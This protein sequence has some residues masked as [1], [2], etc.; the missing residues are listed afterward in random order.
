MKSA[1]MCSLTF[2]A[3]L[4]FLKVTLSELCSSVRA[5]RAKRFVAEGGSLHLSC[6]V[7]HCGLPGWTGGWYFQEL[8]RIGF[9]LLT[10]SER[11]KMSNY[12]STANSTHLLLHIHNINQSDA[13][14]YMCETSWPNNIIS[15]GHLTYVNVTAAAV[16]AGAGAANSSDRSLSH[17]VLLCFGALMCFPVVLGF[18]WC[19]TR[20]H[21][22]P[23]PPVPPHPRM[24]YAYR[25]KP[26]QEVVYAEV[27]LNDSRRQ[28]DH[29]KQASEPTFY[30]SVHFS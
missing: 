16:G 18:V 25:V 24:S 29:P 26:K 5:S 7:Q 6:E 17:R 12:S 21:H 8:D 28:N 14:A 20:D 27:A 19:L 23:P 1:H 4:C 2:L 30:S 10:P 3:L 22:P 15:K 9:T 11:I 13:G